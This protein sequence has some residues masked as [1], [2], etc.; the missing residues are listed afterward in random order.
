MGVFRWLKAVSS[1]DQKYGC[2]FRNHFSFLP[3]TDTDMANK[4]IFAKKVDIS[5]FEC[6]VFTFFSAE[7]S[8][9]TTNISEIVIPNT[10]KIYEDDMDEA[11]FFFQYRCNKKTRGPMDL[12]ALLD[13]CSR[14]DK[15]QFSAVLYKKTHEI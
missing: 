8:Q 3:N 6:C 2:Q 12:G 10:P 7:A 1:Q 9:V 15:W 11:C 14:Y 13:T 5:E 4:S